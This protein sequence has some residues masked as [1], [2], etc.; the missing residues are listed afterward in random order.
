[1]YTSL[2]KYDEILIYFELLKKE[3]M[4]IYKRSNKSLD[5]DD[6]DI[7]D[8][9]SEKTINLI[10]NE[11][12]R[13]QITMK[14]GEVWQKAIGLFPGFED[15]GIGHESECDVRKCDNSIIIELKN[16]YNTVN[17]GGKKD[18]ERKLYNY[19]IKNQNTEC[20]WGIINQKKNEKKSKRILNINGEEIIKW[21]GKN[22]LTYIFTYK[23]YDYSDIIIMNLRNINAQSV[24]ND[25]IN[26]LP[27]CSP[28]LTGTA[29]PIC[30][31]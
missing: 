22:F 6:L 11:L 17:S 13:K 24:D 21:Q 20:I 14:Y 30:A 3:I 12:K 18:V 10:K 16:K 26:S 28:N 4:K 19:K 2:V 23:G 5:I 1:M 27:S 8:D 31:Y 29:L 9:N 15:L 25:L 7:L